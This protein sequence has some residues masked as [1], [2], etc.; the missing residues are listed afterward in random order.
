MDAVIVAGKS[1]LERGPDAFLEP[2][3]LA[4]VREEIDDRVPGLEPLC[5]TQLK[6]ARYGLE[7]RQR[8]LGLHA[9]RLIHLVRAVRQLLRGIRNQ[10]ETCGGCQ[11]QEVP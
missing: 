10:A 5:A 8:V 7:E 9:G 2:P 1:L 4:H 11:L 6:G 3:A